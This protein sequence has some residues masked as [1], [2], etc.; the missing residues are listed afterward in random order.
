MVVVVV[1]VVGLVLVVVFDVEGGVVV[2]I[3]QLTKENFSWIYTKIY[4]A[5]IYLKRI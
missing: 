2:I 5:K 1:V 3:A 4:L